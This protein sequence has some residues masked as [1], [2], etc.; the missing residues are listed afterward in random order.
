[1]ARQKFESGDRV[2][3]RVRMPGQSDGVGRI[4]ALQP[5][6]QGGV[7][8]RYRVRFPTENFERS[9]SE[10]DLEHASDVTPKRASAAVQTEAGPSWINSSKIRIKK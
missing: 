10:D 4:V 7:S 1:M 2:I 3:L 9:I 5:Q 8:K 6:G